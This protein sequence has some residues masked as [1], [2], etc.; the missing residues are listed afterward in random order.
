[1]DDILYDPWLVAVGS[2]LIG[3][4]L[5]GLIIYFL[6]HSRTD[7][8]TRDIERLFRN[9]VAVPERTPLSFLLNW[10][11][12][13]FYLIL[14]SGIVG[15]T[16]LQDPTSSSWFQI[17]V[18]V[19]LVTWWSMVALNVFVLMDGAALEGRLPSPFL[20]F[21]S[22][23][24][25]VIGHTKS[26]VYTLFDFITKFALGILLY[27]ALSRLSDIGIRS[28]MSVLLVGFALIDTFFYAYLFLT[29]YP[30]FSNWREGRFII[31]EFSWP[32]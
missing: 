21:V 16:L 30:E 25:P 3:G 29:K 23:V 27:G 18:Y 9:R 13:V 6:T 1:V 19:V 12:L 31:D 26:V 5:S 8:S 7:L 11:Y 10:R 14:F 24:L 4:V 2:Q 32:R 22:I 17:G 28:I 15:L 20:L